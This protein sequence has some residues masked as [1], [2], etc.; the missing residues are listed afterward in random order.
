MLAMSLLTS[1]R[2]TCPSARFSMLLME[3]VEALILN[4]RVSSRLM[5]ASPRA[6]PAAYMLP[7]LSAVPIERMVRS[8]ADAVVLFCAFGSL[9]SVP[10]RPAQAARSIA[11]I[12]AAARIL[13]FLISGFLSFRIDERFTGINE[14]IIS[15]SRF[16]KQRGPF[17]RPPLFQRFSFFRRTC[18]PAGSA[19]RHHRDQSMPWAMFRNVVIAMAFVM[20]LRN[21]P[22]SGTTK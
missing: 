22:I 15:H 16:Q 12:P 18:C 3:P 11:A 5:K 21:P 19:G 8:F 1:A 2:S 20:L 6:A 9:T 14:T 10:P 7:P 13:I 17:Y 4:R